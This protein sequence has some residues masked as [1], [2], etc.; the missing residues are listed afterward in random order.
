MDFQDV[1]SR[2][3]RMTSLKGRGTIKLAVTVPKKSLKS[4]AALCFV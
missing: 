4:S 3:S 1:N 2:I